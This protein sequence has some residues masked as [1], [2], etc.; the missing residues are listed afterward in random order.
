ML[1]ID[2]EEPAELWICFTGK[3]GDKP[4]IWSSPPE[5]GHKYVRVLHVREVVGEENGD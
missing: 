4:D 1:K 2:K 3:F 5:G